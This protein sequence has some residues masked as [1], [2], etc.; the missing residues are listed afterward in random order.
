ME[1]RGQDIQ[2]SQFYSAPLYVNP[3]FA[4]SAHKDRIILH[5][6]LQ[7]PKLTGKYITSL[8]SAD[9][10][11]PKYKSG[12]GILA[13]K[14]WQGDNTITSTEIGIQ[15]SYE[16]YLNERYTFRPGLQMSYVNRSINYAS[17]RFPDQFDDDQ[18]YFG[19][20][21]SGSDRIH[22]ADA[23]AGGIFY[24]DKMW[25]GVAV[26]HLNRPNQSFIGD[27]ARL[28]VKYSF[29]AGYTINIDNNEV[30][31]I[32]EKPQ[33]TL[34]PTVHYKFQGKSDQV[35]FGFFGIYDQLIFGA[36]Y[37]GLEVKRYQRNIQNNESMILLA[38]WKYQDISF[39]YSYDFT[40]SKLTPARTGGSHEFNITYVRNKKKRKKP[41]K[42]MPCPNFYKDF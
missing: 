18:G 40:I 4:G 11:F 32:M 29:T 30:G 15:Y 20:G 19:P 8:I 13:I 6:R 3:A 2:F 36:W 10:Y 41:M 16:L 33:I 39:M 5:Q 34:V 26:S 17:L 37:R 25:F 38:G 9:T 31:S 1:L 24:D 35:D 42:R 7:W 27:V 14:D 28:P 22:Y 21:N 12:L 23:S